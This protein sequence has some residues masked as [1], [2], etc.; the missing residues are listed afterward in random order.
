MSDIIVLPGRHI[1]LL[2]S[3]GFHQQEASS[4]MLSSVENM[5]IFADVIVYI[6]PH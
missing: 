1:H 2:Q 6:C 5:R 3:G 4:L